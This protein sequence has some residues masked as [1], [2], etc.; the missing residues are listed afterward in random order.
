MTP[1]EL[2]ALHRRCFTLP[3]PWDA[4]EFAALLATPAAFLCCA[5]GGFALG[6]A[7]A[8]EAELLTLAVDP[9][10]RR[11]GIGRGLLD[12]FETAS[13]AR[14]A[15]TAFLE[16]AATNNA[17]RALYAAAG[18]QE[19]GLRRGYYRAPDGAAEDAVILTRTL[20]AA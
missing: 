8:G 7:A 10:Q 2:A 13:I 5:P 3:R 17:A 12:R 11:R 6:R 15:Q 4:D 18:W 19:A 14:G 20:A 16:V 9:G 1:A